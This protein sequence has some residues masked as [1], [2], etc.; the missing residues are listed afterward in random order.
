MEKKVRS[1]TFMT[2]KGMRTEWKVQE[3]IEREEEGW[4]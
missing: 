3:A 1:M 4:R 2:T